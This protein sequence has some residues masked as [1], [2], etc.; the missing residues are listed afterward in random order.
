MA[1]RTFVAA[2]LFAA[3]FLSTPTAHAAP[4][5]TDTPTA[6]ADAFYRLYIKLKVMD[7]PNAKERAQFRPLLSP[8][9]DAALAD[10][11]KAE[12]LYV[13][14]T[15]NEAPPLYEGDLFSSLV[16]GA[17]DYKVGACDGDASR[18]TCT[19]E[20]T[21]VDDTKTITKWHDRLVL[22]HGDHGWR[23]DDL[24]YGGDWEFGPH[25]KLS[26][27]LKDVVK[28]SQ[29]AEEEKPD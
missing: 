6:T 19:I 17:T 29:E 9:L 11:D 28:E 10:A 23:I 22:V 20:L 16:E 26:D 14:K 3:A 4:P 25:G 13:K 5:A 8:A 2:A 27:V 7:V 21:S 12:A 24:E 1:N 18:S 15:K